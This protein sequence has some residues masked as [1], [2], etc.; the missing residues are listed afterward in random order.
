[1]EISAEKVAV[2]FPRPN[3]IPTILM[4]AFAGSPVTIYVSGCFFGDS[5][6]TR[7]SVARLDVL[8]A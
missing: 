8:T 6:A 1:M 7:G 2:V 5:D 4:L 3:F